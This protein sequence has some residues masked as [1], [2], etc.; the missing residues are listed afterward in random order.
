MFL[1]IATVA[2][3]ATIFGGLVTLV[4]TSEACA[5]ESVAASVTELAVTEQPVSG[6]QVAKNPINE[7]P[8]ASAARVPLATPP[9]DLL[10][11]SIRSELSVSQD[12]RSPTADTNFIDI[13]PWTSIESL[14]K[15]A[16]K[17]DRQAAK[18]EALNNLKTATLLREK[19][20]VIREIA[21]ELLLLTQNRPSN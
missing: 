16:R 21:V 8:A 9:S 6:N 11:E 5:D 18:L 4:R 1:R 2:L 20:L 10:Y 7:K 15:V 12:Q 14:L 17:I 19:S 3:I 13:R